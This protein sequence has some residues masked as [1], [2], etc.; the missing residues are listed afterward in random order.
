VCDNSRECD[1]AAKHGWG[2][3][4]DPLL[5]TR[6]QVSAEGPGAVS[7]RDEVPAI[8]VHPRPAPSAAPLPKGLA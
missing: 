2:R 8:T 5:A 3:T 6:V 7:A 4:R 1:A